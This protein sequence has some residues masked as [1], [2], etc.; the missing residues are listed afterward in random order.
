[1]AQYDNP[2]QWFGSTDG[3]IAAGIG[4][5]MEPIAQSLTATNRAAHLTLS[6]VQGLGKVLDGLAGKVVEA[7][8]NK[9]WYWGNQEGKPD[10]DKGTNNIFEATEASNTLLFG[11]N[12][13][14]ALHKKVD[15]L[16]AKID[17]PKQ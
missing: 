14:A 13:L 7:I 2:D 16:T 6:A 10:K 11:P 17:A 15:A 8:G 12:G 3:K 9:R 5:G 4:G 1:M